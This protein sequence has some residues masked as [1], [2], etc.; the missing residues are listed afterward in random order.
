MLPT[1]QDENKAMYFTAAA[2]A[3]TSSLDVALPY[4]L[5]WLFCTQ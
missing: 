2:A 1:E 5:W 3:I 4:V